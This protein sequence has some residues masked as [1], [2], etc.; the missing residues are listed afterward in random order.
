M[1]LTLF[2]EDQNAT[3]VYN[4]CRN[5]R[6]DYR[7]EV[8]MGGFATANNDR[9]DLALGTGSA[10]PC[11]IILIHIKKG[12]GALA[13]YP[14]HNEPLVVVSAVWDMV[15]Q[16]GAK[17]AEVSEIVLAGGMQATSEETINYRGTLT[18]Q[19][20]HRYLGAH[21]I[22]PR[23]NW[24]QS[25]ASCFYLPRQEKAALFS[26]SPDF[27]CRGVGYELTPEGIHLQQFGNIS[28]ATRIM[29]PAQE[30]QSVEGEI[31]PVAGIQHPPLTPPARRQAQM[32]G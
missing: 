8:A 22:W 9:Q 13:H 11:V 6:P 7:A 32:G 28:P 12:L 18:T 17:P 14:G 24:G 27:A 2:L 15:K 30:Q 25:P 3:A 16:T 26:Q 5:L 10:G 23:V 4:Q 21:I 19:L 29:G 20:M 1:P 31:L